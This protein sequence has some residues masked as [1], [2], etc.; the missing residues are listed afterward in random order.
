MK[1]IKKVAFVGNYLPRRCGIATFTTD[2][3]E[4]FVSS[5]PSVQCYAIPITDIEEGYQY[6]ERVRFEIK[7]QELDTYKA[8]ADFLNLNDVDIV[9]LQFEYGI[10]GGKAGSYILSLLRNLK[11][12]VITTLHTVLKNPNVEQRRVMDELLVISDY[13]VVMSQKG[14][15]ILH[16]V[17]K[18]PPGKVRLIPHGIHDVP[19][20]D[21]NFYKDKYG[22]EGKIVILTFGLLSPQK[23]IEVVLRALPEV[24]KNHPN[25]VYLVAGVTHPNLLKHEGEK[26]RISLQR[27]ANE[28]GIKGQVIFYNKFVS[29]DELKELIT[30]ADIYITPYLEETQITSGTLAYSFGA[31]NAVISTPY[32][33]AYELLADGRGI[34]VPFGDSDSITKAIIRL[35]QNEVERHTMRKNAYLLGR[36]MTWNKVS[37][38]YSDLFTEARQKR[39]AVMRKKNPL[40]SLDEQPPILPEIKLDH[41]IR[42]TDSIGIFQHAKHNVPNFAEGYCMD[43]N[44][45][46]LILTVLLE[47]LGT[48]NSLILTDLA[49]RYLGFVRYAWNEKT[50]R[51]RSFLTFQRKWEEN[52]FSEDSHGR[53]VWALGTCIGRSRNEGFSQMTA[54]IFEYALTPVS[55]FSSPRAW[56]FALIGAQEYQRRFPG[57][58][59]TRNSMEML[60][61]KLIKLYDENRRT[62]WKW[63][64][65]VLSYSN[66]VIPRALIVSGRGL[67]NEKILGCGIESLN[68]LI[69][70]QTSSRGYFQ[71][72]GTDKIFECGTSKPVFDQQPIEAYSTISACLEAYI[73]T[74]DK[75]WYNEAEKAFQWFL[76]TNDLGIPLYD[77]VN[78]GCYDGLHVDRVNRN[79]G[80]E[81]T[82]AFLLS[83][84]EMTNITNI[85]ETFKEPILE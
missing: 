84:Y 82:I 77:P 19:F 47:N 42:M 60:S 78:G 62:E 22:V 65:P 83:L 56:A 75:R 24:I 15:E 27:L 68:W 73:T 43:D 11:M 36:E 48:I 20:I 76:G 66:A 64:E 37:Q 67:A 29:I 52:N 6:P 72:V 46:A 5:N 50:A 9:C 51:F 30:L 31:G 12:P 40:R 10:F 38:Q 7:E 49:T 74:K 34:L 21:P 23:G 69:T 8:A 54:E 57:D 44:S 80:A 25:I 26:Y 59:S 61:T 3:C 18:I 28:L 55:S 33:H 17:F 63:F 70:M 4:S 58:R 71:P 35:I 79:Q 13:V 32:W 39:S 45:R 81:S 41:L 2:L 53:A 14:V 16:E 85:I 1:N